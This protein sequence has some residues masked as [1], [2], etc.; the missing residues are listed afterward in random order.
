MRNKTH[1]IFIGIILILL[2]II[3]ISI[4]M[5]KNGDVPNNI[6]NKPWYFDCLNI[7]GE[8]ETNKTIAIIDSRL[9]K[10]DDLNECNIIYEYNFI[11]NS[12]DVTD[13]YGHGTALTSV[14]VGTKN[15]FI[16]ILKNPKLIILKV[17]DNFGSSNYKNVNLAILKAIELKVDIINLSMG[18]NFENEEI[19]NSINLALEND[20]L[21]V[22]SIGDFQND[23]ATYPARM[24]G[25]ISVESQIEDGSK[26][27]F[28]NNFDSTV[29]IPG[30]K[31]P[32]ISLNRINM[33]FELTTESGSSLSSIIFCGLL[34]RSNYLSKLMLDF[35]YL[36]ECK[37]TN[38]FIDENR[39]FR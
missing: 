36:N 39:I 9:T 24:N 6:D 31:M 4:I 13:D 2:V 1:F 29:R 33:Q 19:S 7:E 25:V 34:A 18:M 22:S 10:T 14:L 37:I 32:V 8:S 15:N 35:D 21:V 16:G 28:S 20:I 11:N 12:Y 30:Y 5:K 3:F 17:M 27:L 23:N 26:Y 38:K